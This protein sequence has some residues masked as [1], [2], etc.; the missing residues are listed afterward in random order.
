MPFKRLAVERSVS[1]LRLVFPAARFLRRFLS[2]S[3]LT[4]R[5]LSNDTHGHGEAGQEQH[6]DHKTTAFHQGY[7]RE[8]EL[9]LANLHRHHSK[10]KDDKK[11]RK[12]SAANAPPVANDQLSHFESSRGRPKN[13]T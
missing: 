2:S 4:P 3:L 9:V 7:S 8:W 11:Y 6:N 10:N 13:K 12:A 5:F 1:A